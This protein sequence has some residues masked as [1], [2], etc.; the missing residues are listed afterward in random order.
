MNNEQFHYLLVDES[1][2]LDI[3]LAIHKMTQASFYLLPFFYLQ[4]YF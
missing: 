2:L 1:N 3:H 4:S